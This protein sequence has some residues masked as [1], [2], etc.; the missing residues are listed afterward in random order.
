MFT[1][2]GLQT[3]AHIVD[4]IGP[5]L[6]MLVQPDSRQGALELTP[7]LRDA[8]AAG[9]QVHAYTFRSDPGQIPAYATSF[10]QLLDIFCFTVGIDGVFTDFPDQV[11]RFL[12]ARN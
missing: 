8:H 5:G 4:G 11:V 6:D 9:L 7:L 10:A 12:E 1:A 3:L 2:E